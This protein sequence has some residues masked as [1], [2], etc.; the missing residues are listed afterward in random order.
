MTINP[1]IPPEM[2]MA[3]ADGELDAISAKRVERAM[4]VDAQLSDRVDAYKSQRAMLAGHFAP[5]LDQAPPA[6]LTALL[7]TNVTPLQPRRRTMPWAANLAAVAA[8]LVIGLVV[9]RT[10]DFGTTAPIGSHGGALV[11]QGGLARALDT[12]LASAQPAD[13]ETRIGL[14]F[15][16]QAG[17]IC[18]TFDGRALSGIACRDGETWQVDR[19]MRGGTQA[20]DYRQAGSSETMQAAQAMMAGDPMDAAAERAA[21]GKG[22][23]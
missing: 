11:A 16:D 3:Y 13:A 20:S 9:G 4:E 14:T 23:H 19:M 5:V 6:R 15:R 17:H 22:W 10:L 2:L 7:E 18:R 1:E 21:M 8:A 12:Q